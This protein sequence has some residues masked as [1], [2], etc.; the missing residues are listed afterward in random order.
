MIRSAYQEERA[1]AVN[2]CRNARPGER[3]FTNGHSVVI[4]DDTLP[5]PSHCVMAPFPGGR[6]VV[7]IERKI[8][9]SGP[10]IS[11][12]R[13]APTIAML[14]IIK[15]KQHNMGSAVAVRQNV[16]RIIIVTRHGPE[17]P[18]E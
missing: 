7:A 3:L 5:I 2:P 13:V 10:N 8:A 12:Q 9:S 16:S 6:T 11:R 1:A 14:R 15:A 4:G 17:F 18:K